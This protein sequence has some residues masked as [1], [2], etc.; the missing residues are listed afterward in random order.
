MPMQGFDN[1]DVATLVAQQQADH[2]AA[3]CGVQEAAAPSNQQQVCHFIICI[4]VRIP[5]N[6]GFMRTNLTRSTGARD[7]ER[8]FPEQVEFGM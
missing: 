1:M 7:S 8:I 3:V 5:T 2:K 6:A 4:F